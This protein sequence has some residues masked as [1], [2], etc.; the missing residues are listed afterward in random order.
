MIDKLKVFY[1]VFI[2]LNF[3]DLFAYENKII[4]KINNSV[5][6]SYE[7]KNKILT[8]LILANEDIN[9]ENI[10]KTK[11]LVF[12]SL[13]DLKIKEYET[14]KFKVE[15]SK[16]ELIS[17]LDRYSSVSADNFEKKFQL[18][19]LNFELFKKDLKTEIAWRKLIYAL[20]NKKIQ[21]NES[22]IDL[23]LQNILQENKKDNK[24]FKLSEIVV[25]FNNQSE[26]D[27][28]IKELSNQIRKI[29]FD[30]TLLKYSE[31]INKGNLGDLGWVSSKSLS[32]NII[33]A[34]KDLN[35][36][37]VT[38]PIIINNTVLF[39]KIKDIR[40]VELKKDNIE[41]I[42][43]KILDAKKNQMFN[44]YSNSHLSKLKNL[45]SIEYQ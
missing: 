4:A 23:E 43:E 39:L 14:K 30:K 41:N 44:L 32:K 7:L 18:Y 15:V 25:N 10:N 13:I 38:S 28:K 29:G 19:D 5:I 9:Q 36:G 34:L 16:I 6:T 24:E 33:S 2:F 11:P 22:E 12:Q 20:F 17:S 40:N 42:K 1:Y 35:I 3:F 31:S 21:V 26:K 8:T 45:S 27:I 37:D